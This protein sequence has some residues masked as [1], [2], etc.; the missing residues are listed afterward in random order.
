MRIDAHQHFWRLANP[1]CN[2]PTPAEDKIHTDFEP[3]D[4]EA[5]LSAHSITGSIVVQAAPFLAETLYLLDL[6]NE[7]SFV[8]GVVGWIDF[9]SSSALA[10]LD[11]FASYPLFRGVRPMLQSIPDTRWML[12]PSFHRIYEQL[13]KRSLTFDALVLPAHLPHLSE[14]AA[15]HPGLSIIIDHAAKPAIRNG[16]TGFDA[17]AADISKLA[18]QKN[19]SCKISGLLTEAGPGAR[20]ADL[21]PWLEHIYDIFGPE[22]LLWGSDWPVVLMEGSYARWVSVCEEWLADKPERSRELIFGETACRVYGLAGEER[23]ERIHLMEGK[24]RGAH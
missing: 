2:W 23:D 10:D 9:A 17:W 8:K 16:M 13:A 1:F 24:G 6:A 3:A 19:V 21:R 18:A 5:L 20:L 7:A 11:A 15:R 14:L 4:L 12:N 22:R